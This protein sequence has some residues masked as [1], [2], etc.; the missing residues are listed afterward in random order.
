MHRASYLVLDEVVNVSWWDGHAVGQRRHV[1]AAS[2]EG[3]DQGCDRGKHLGAEAARLHPLGEADSVEGG[4]G[5]NLY[6]CG[7]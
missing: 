7:R 2:A 3:L 1:Q 4:E 5:S 6:I